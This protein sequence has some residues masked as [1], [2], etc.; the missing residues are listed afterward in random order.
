MFN[1]FYFI[2][3]FG[4]AFATL[5]IPWIRGQRVV[6]PEGVVSYTGSVSW[7][8]GIPGILMG[9][10]TLFFWMGR[11]KF[12]HVPPTHPGAIGLL[13]VLSGSALFL[14][15]GV[16]IYLHDIVHEPGFFQ[17]SID[18]GW[19]KLSPHVLW[20]SLLSLCALVAFAVLFNIRQRLKEDD[21]FLAILFY[22]I[23]Q[24]F[25]RQPKTT[26]TPG[27]K[28]LEH[29]WFFGAA[30]R[31]YG[32]D[33]VEGPI[34]VLKIMTIF[35]FISV[36]WALFDQHS[37]TW[38]LQAQQMDRSVVLSWWQWLLVGLLIGLVVSGAVSVTLT[39]SPIGR[40]IGCAI[41][42]VVGTVAGPVIGWTFDYF[43]VTQLQ[44]SQ[45]PAAN[46]F[47]VMILIPYTT[48]GLYPLRSKIGI[49]PTPLRRMTLGMFIAGL[50]F[51]PVAIIQ[52]ILDAGT[53]VHVVWQFIPYVVI[54]VAEV[55][56]SIT[57]LEFAYS[58]AP[59]RMKSVIMGFWLLNV[60]IGNLLVV[61]IT[62]WFADMS[63]NRLAQFFWVF[64]ALMAGAAGLFGL[65][66]AFYKYQDYT[67]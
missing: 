40:M 53:P 44:A 47:L 62:Y 52:Q 11:K 66:A 9:L 13:D 43:E 8:F 54:T 55:M 59:K 17:L 24:L 35:I 4:S 48:F 45:I 50:S 46:P 28:S 61:L 39:R 20:L 65:R 19:I 25:I 31:K 32:K 10:A 15:I 64:A 26:A 6:S 34:A 60:T 51:V 3:N 63:K 27:S 49:E 23:K 29:N 12:V 30:V 21:G 7:A 18:L 16:P 38:I 2:I 58:Q 36:F 37:S 67:Q 22:S 42:A 33:V 1:A 41:G 14:V 5:I 57:G 56:I